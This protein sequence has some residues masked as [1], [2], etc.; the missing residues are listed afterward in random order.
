MVEVT[1]WQENGYLVSAPGARHQ[2][3]VIHGYGGNSEEMLGLTVDL[4]S[5]LALRM[6]V[7][8]LPGHGF[9]ASQPLTRR[10]ALLSL[11]SA[12][13]ALENPDFLI[14]HS[15]GARLGLAAGLPT[16]VLLSMPGSADFDGSRQE[17]LRTLR[18]RRVTEGPP[19]QGLE[20]IL[21]AEVEPAARTLMLR[22]TREP[23][24]VKSLAIAWAKRGIPCRTIRDSS[25][26]DII[27]SPET[28]KV[29]AKWLQENL[30]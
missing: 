2:G 22:A 6:L 26:N 16:A 15:L 20:E 17:L 28:R 14:G 11:K 4:A 19:L 25:H 27:S 30:S 29:I 23:E 5:R 12:L 7:F 3:L 10:A 1:R 8:T 13:A 24:S 21:T 9:P 18:V